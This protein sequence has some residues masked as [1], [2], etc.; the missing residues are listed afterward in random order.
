MKIIIDKSI[1][2]PAYKQIVEQVMNAIKNSELVNG[3]KLPSERHL[4]T[5]LGV[6]RGTITKAYNELANLE[7]VTLIKGKGCFVSDEKTFL[8]LGR[9]EKAVLM[10]KNTINNLEDLGFSMSEIRIFS[11]IVMMEKEKNYSAIK[12]GIID[13]NREALHA[14]QRQIGQLKDIAISKYLLTEIGNASLKAEIYDFDLVI[15]TYKHYK[16]ILEELPTI[17]DRLIRV[18]MSPSKKTMIEIARVAHNKNIGILF[19]SKNYLGVIRNEL[20]LVDIGLKEGMCLMID[21]LDKKQIS[22]FVKNKEIVII[23][24]LTFFEVSFRRWLMLHLENKQVIEFDYLIERGNLLYL[25]ETI[26]SLMIS[27]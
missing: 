26:R 13:C 2:L 7:V 24:P 18:S 20:K 21:S 10:I 25:E 14:I 12:I 3:D 6:S 17:E 9:K 4:S 19:D 23:P 1:G 15:T 16:E 27:K 22:M 5:K 11:E 8:S